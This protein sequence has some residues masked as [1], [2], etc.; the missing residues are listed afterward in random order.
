MCIYIYIYTD[1]ERGRER[2]R[3][4]WCFPSPGKD[5]RG[6]DRCLQVRGVRLHAGAPQTTITM[7]IIMFMIITCIISVIS[8][9]II[10]IISS[11]I[12]SSSSN[13]STIIGVSQTSHTELHGRVSNV[14]SALWPNV[15]TKRQTDMRACPFG[16]GAMYIYIYIYIYTQIH[17]CV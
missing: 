1:R 9:S 7:C 5:G 4:T 6:G 10:C 15:R 8:I 16:M 11:G 17:I 14:A 13:S 3:D 2:E 12:I